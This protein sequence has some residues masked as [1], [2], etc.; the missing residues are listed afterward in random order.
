LDVSPTIFTPDVTFEVAVGIL[1]TTATVFDPDVITLTIIS[2]ES[3]DV[4]P[5]L[6]NPS[7]ETLISTGIL[8]ATA[9]VFSPIVDTSSFVI[10]TLLSID[11]T[12]YDPSMLW[13]SGY[14]EGRMVLENI[15]GVISVYELGEA[16][17]MDD[18]SGSIEIVSM[19]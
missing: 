14:I 8:D 13:I 16:Q 19:L 7:V 5:T 3:L 11:P 6:Y 10:A 17:T 4:S 12:I 2:A 1:D 18:I 15:D 9:S